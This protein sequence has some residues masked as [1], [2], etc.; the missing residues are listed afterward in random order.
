V[1]ECLTVY[2]EKDA[3]H[4]VYGAQKAAN[5]MKLPRGTSSC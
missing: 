4:V 5:S 3:L 1:L 2:A